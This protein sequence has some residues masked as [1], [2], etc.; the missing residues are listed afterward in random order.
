MLVLIVDDEPVARMLHV[1]MLARMKDVTAVGVD[2]VAAAQ[3]FLDASTPDLIILD[4]QLPDGTALDVLMAL[5][6][7]RAA[8][9]LVIVTGHVDELPGALPR[10][11][12][13]P[14]L[15]KP[16]SMRELQ[17]LVE[18][19]RQAGAPP[20]PFAPL[21]YVQL[22]C[23]SQQSVVIACVA[24]DGRPLGAIALAKGALESA[25]DGSGSGV[26][27]LHRL[28]ALGPCEVRVLPPLPP[29]APA[30]PAPQV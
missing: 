24:A 18:H 16:A 1:S 30:G 9:H 8:V 2:S 11:R 17:Q 25:R 10:S 28:S 20:A 7:R 14:V 13:M 4:V 12:R 26:A 3:A 22:A 15:R 5:A 23:M 21:E 19:F 27:A 6:A 29:A